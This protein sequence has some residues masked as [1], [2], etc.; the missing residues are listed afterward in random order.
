VISCSAL[1]PWRRPFAAFVK[2]LRTDARFYHDN[3]VA[4]L[5]GYRDICKRVD[6]ELARLFKTLPRLPYGVRPVP[7]F[8]A[9]TQ[10]TAYY[11]SGDIRNAEPGYFYANTYALDQRPRYEMIPLALHEAVPGHHLQIAIA[12]ELSG[13]PE[14]R[15]DADFTVFVEGWALYSERLGIEMGLFNDPYDNFGRLLYEMWRACRLVVDPGMHALGWSRD[16]AI[17]FMSDNTALSPLNIQNEVDRYINWPGQA[18]AYKIGELKIRELRGKAEA[19]LGTK[20]DL[21]EFHDVVLGAGAVPLSTL[22]RRVHEWLTGVSS[23]VDVAAIRTTA[24]APVVQEPAPAVLSEDDK[25]EMLLAA[26]EKLE[27]AVFIRNDTE[28][29]AAQA[30]QHMRIKWGR[31]RSD[32]RTAAQFIDSVAS[33]SSVTGQP[34]MIRFADGREQPAEDFLNAELKRI[35]A[36]N[37]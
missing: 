36:M 17:A 30:V 32:I 19:A 18:T 28:H 22:E 23:P 29:T 5:A 33:R 16:K 14:F 35:D 31:H 9:P 7:R 25:I 26:V 21:R 37:P 10:T 8:M 2:Y 20:F 12:K 1:K 13:L 24:S 3:E 15:K 34:Y 27:G 4:L 6:P 11:Q